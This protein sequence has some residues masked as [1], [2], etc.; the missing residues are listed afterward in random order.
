MSRFR[1]LALLLLLTAAV[2][3]SSL[4]ASAQIPLFGG[5]S[6]SLIHI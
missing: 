2:S 3:A 1:S 5:S 4:P 6:L